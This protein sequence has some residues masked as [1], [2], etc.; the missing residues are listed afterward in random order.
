[1]RFNR[2]SPDTRQH[3]APSLETFQ[4]TKFPAKD[5]Q[6]RASG[7]I[8]HLVY[9]FQWNRTVWILEFPRSVPDLVGTYSKI[10]AEIVVQHEATQGLIWTS[11]CL[12]P[13]T[14]ASKPPPKF[15][16]P[17]TR[18]LQEWHT[19]IP[20]PEKNFTQDDTKSC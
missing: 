17:D 4:D 12:L 5:V 15:W 6:S 3:C 8:C 19:E 13:E 2:R 11:C 1:M 20:L 7:R 16:P 10:C 18:N 14:L 9:V